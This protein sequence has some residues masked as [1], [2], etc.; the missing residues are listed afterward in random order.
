MQKGYAVHQDSGSSNNVKLTSGPL[1]STMVFQMR[2]S[3][4]RPMEAWLR[5]QEQQ[6]LHELM[7]ATAKPAMT[8][9]QVCLAQGLPKTTCMLQRHMSDAA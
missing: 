3:L 4:G 7:Q 6:V 8:Q 2:D 1:P 9:E 5:A